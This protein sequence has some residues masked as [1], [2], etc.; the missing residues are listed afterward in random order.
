MLQDSPFRY[1]QLGDF[2]VAVTPDFEDHHVLGCELEEVEVGRR[3]L[4]EEERGTRWRGQGRTYGE[5]CSVGHQVTRLDTLSWRMI[6]FACCPQRRRRLCDV[7][8][9]TFRTLHPV[10]ISPTYRLAQATG[11]AAFCTSVWYQLAES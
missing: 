3:L 8:D 5:C 4:R 2:D 7:A 1:D 6:P 11:I 10:G 9:G